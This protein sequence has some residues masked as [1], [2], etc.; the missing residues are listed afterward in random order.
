MFQIIRYAAIR[1]LIDNRKYISQEDL[2]KVFN[3]K[4]VVKNGKIAMEERIIEENQ[5]P[6]DNE[7]RLGDYK[8]SSVRKKK[9]Q[10]K[11]RGILS[12]EQQKKDR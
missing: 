8:E 7:I 3:T 11:R 12:E 1:A 9:K 10:A 2:I 5:K 6:D 4:Y